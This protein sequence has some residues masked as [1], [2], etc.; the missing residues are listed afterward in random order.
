MPLGDWHGVST[1]AAGRVVALEVSR[2]GLVGTIPTEIAQ[3]SNLTRLWLDGN[4]LHGSIPDQLGNLSSL[5][6]LVLSGNRLTGAIPIQLG[7]L[8]GLEL[9]WLAGNRLTG[10]IPAALGN[11][12]ALQ[13]L[14]LSNNQF[15]GPV[16]R[17]LGNLANLRDLNLSRNRFDGSLPG[18]L[19][20]LANLT[21]LWLDNSLSRNL[22]TGPV[23]TAF[24]NLS[25][26]LEFSV[27]FTHLCAPSDE[28]FA[29]WYEAIPTVYGWL[30]PC[31]E[32]RPVSATSAGLEL[33]VEYDAD[34]D[35]TSVPSPADFEILV[36]GVS[37]SVTEVEVRGRVAVLTLASRLEAGQGVT[38]GYTPGDAPL[39]S[40][41]LI[42]APSL[43]AHP[44]P[45][46][47][48]PLTV[49]FGAASYAAEEGGVSAAVTIRLSSV[50]GRQ[51]VIPIFASLTGGT[52]AE[53]YSGVPATVTFASHETERTFGFAA[54]ADEV[55]DDGE[56]VVLGFG[57]PLPALV[58]AGTTRTTTV[59]ILDDPADVP[60]VSLSY[61]SAAYAVAEGGSV[62]VTV[63]LSAMPE[64]L[65]EIP[66]SI[67]HAGGSVAGDYSGVPASVTFAADET[68]RSFTFR[69]LPD[70]SEDD[71]ETVTLGFGSQL[72]PAVASADPSSATVTI[73]H[74]PL[75]QA[76]LRTLYEATDGPNWSNST[77]W[78]SEEPL[79]E[80]HGIS[81]STDHLVISLR[82][83]GLRGS[84]PPELG[85]LAN[86]KVLSLAYNQLSGPIPPEL[87]N[88]TGLRELWLSGNEALSGSIPS[89]A[90]NLASLRYLY[91]RETSLAG[92][93]P[94]RLTELTELRVLNFSETEL[95]APA[96]AA[97]QT[98]ASGVSS[99]RGPT[100]EVQVSTV[101]PQ[102]RIA[103]GPSP[104]AEG[105]A[106]AFTLTR[107]GP[108]GVALTVTVSVTEG[109]AMLAANPPAS[110]IFGADE[111]SAT[112]TAATEDDA[113]VEEASAVTAAI[114]SGE[115]YTA[116]ADAGSA[117][118]SVEDND[119]ATFEVSFDREAIAEGQAATLTV[120]IANG[121]TFAEDQTIALDFAGGTATK[122]TDYTVP[123]ESLVLAAGSTSA[124][125]TVTA[126]DDTDSEGAE[127][128][129]VAARHE[130]AAI[131]S[132]SVTIEASDAAPPEISI[133]AGTSPVTEGTAAAF[134]LTRTGP[135]TE[136]LAVAVSVT[137]SAA[138]LAA[139]PA[140]SVTF[141]A[142]ESS[143][144][145]TVATDDDAV[146]EGSSAVTAAVASG[147][148]YS[149][150][151]DAG[152]AQATVEDNDAPVWTVSPSAVEVAEGDTA[153]LT[154]SAG[155]VTFAE[156]Q[157]LEL[158]TAGTA[159]AVDFALSPPAPQIAAGAGSVAV[160]VTAVDDAAEEKAETVRLTVLHGGGGVGTATVTIAA[161]DAATGDARLADLTLS[162]GELA[163]RGEVERYAMTVP[164]DL[165]STTVTATPNDP[166]AAVDVSPADTDSDPANGHQVR[167]AEGANAVVVTV[168]S[169]DGQATKT[170][171]VQVTRLAADRAEALRRSERDLEDLSGNVPF[172]LWSE[173]GTLW[174]A[175]WWSVGLV[176]FDLETHGRLSGRDIAVA[177]D[178]PSPT[179]LWS[180]GETLWASDYGGGVFGYRLSDGGRVPGEDL[181]ATLK[182]A[183][184]DTPTGL[185]SDGETLWVADH[186]DERVYAYRL[187]DKARDED[188]EFA[189]EEGTR[190][191]GLWSDGTTAWTADLSAGRVAAYRLSD[192]VRDADRDY[193]TSTVGNEA[194]VSLWS[195]G[196]TLWVG[197]R[198]DEKLYAY[199]LEAE[200]AEASADATL[201]SLTLS[202]V[203]IGTFD[204]ATAD[205][206]ASV[207]PAVA[208]TT[209]TATPTSADASVTIA[210]S[211][212][213]TTDG[214]RDVS[215]A[216]GANTVTATVTA[217]DGQTT[218]T[219][220][221][222]VTREYAALPAIS[223]A[224]GTSPVTEG[225][226]AAFTLTRTGLTAEARTVAVSVTESGA[227]LAANPPASVTFGTGE[228]SATL[229]A[230]TDDDAVVEGASAVTAAVASGEG[231]ATAANA[232]SAQVSV[233]DNDAATFEVSFDAEAIAEGQ[234]ATLTVGIANGVT[235]A[236][237]QTIALD[238]AGGTATKGTDYTVSAESV[239]LAAGSTSVQATL[240]AVDDTDP[241]GAETV[242][243]A[244][245]HEGAAI[246]SASMTLEA[247][248]AALP[249][250]SIAAGASPVT[251]GKAAAFTLTRTGPTAEALTVAVS[252][253]E[254]TAMLVANPPSS[255][256]FGTG[257]S[258]AALTVATE[259]DAVVEGASTVTAV[260]AIGEGY[261]A[262]AN[263]A[264]AQVTVEDN[265]TAAF[266]VTAAPEAIAEGESATLTVAIANGVTFAEDQA[267]AL[268]LSGT[269]SA[270][271]YAGLPAALT[272][273]AGASSTAAE[274]T[275]SEDREDEEPETVMVAASHGGVA[276]GSATVTIRSVSHDA[277]LAALS[278]SGVDIG[279][280]A[281]SQ[282]SYMAS[283]AHGTSGTTVTATATHSGAT[284]AILPGAEVSLAEGANEIA[285]TVTA[286]DG[287]TA[288]TY[289]VTVTRVGLPAVSIAGASSPVTEGMAAA[290]EVTL[291][292]AA[293][294]PLTVALSVAESGSALSGTPPASVSF[295]QGDT[296]ATLSVPTQG[297]QV[298]EA[299]S[300]VTA[301]VTAGAG[302]TLGAA[303]SA[304]V[305]VEDDDEAAFTVTAA[306]EAIAEGESATLT[307]A[308]SNGATFAEDQS[309]ALSVSGTASPADYSGL[310]AAVTL[311]A[312]ASAVT[313]ELAAEADQAEEEAETVT[314][315]AAHAGVS[316]GSATV[317]I[318]SVSHDATLAALSLSGVDIGTFSS[319][320]TVYTASV[321]HDISS[322]TV[323]A[324]AT[325]PR[326][327]VSILPSTE[328][329][330][331]EGV[332]EI[333]VTVTAED[334]RSTQTYAVTVTRVGLPV[335]SIVA[336][337]SPVSEGERV[338]YTVSRT[339]PTTQELTVQASWSYSDR[340]EVQTMPVLFQAGRR[341]KIPH[342]QKHD[343]KVI[344]EDVTV[345]LTLED[346]EGYTVAAE[347]RSAQVVLEDNDVAQFAL[348]LD[349]GEIAE[350][351]SGT[352][353]VEITNGVTF[354][355]DQAITF[356]F[357]GSTATKG[358][359][360]AVSPES[361]TLRSGADAATATVTALDD[362][363]EE[364]GETV[365]VTAKHAGGT[366]GT[367]TLTITNTAF[368]PLTAQFAGVPESHDGMAAFGF[369]LRFSE[370]PAVSYRTLRDTAFEVAGGTV[371]RARRLEPPS[372]LRWQITAE[373]ASGAD[374]T[375]VLP[376]SAACDKPAAICTTGGKPLSS[377][378]EATIKGPGSE[379]SGEGFSLAPA[380]SSPSGLWSDGDTAWVADLEDARLYAYRSEDG[381]RLPDRDI[382]TGPAPM[383]LW[384][385][386][387]TL[388]V[389]GL[390][391]GL[392]AHR[393]SNG[394]RLVARDLALKASAAPSGVWSDGKTVWVSD[395]LGD[396][397]HAYRLADG[398]REAGRDIRLAGGNLMPVGLWSDGETLW[399][400]D[401]R[402]LLYA[403]RLSDGGREPSRDVVAG[404]ADSDPTGLWSG[405]GTL[406]STS[407]EGSRVRAYRLPALPVSEG[408]P[409]KGRGGFLPARAAS[410]PAIPDPALKTAIGAALG[411]ASGEAVSLEELAG[412]E[413]LEA[414]EAGIR[415]LAGLEA[416]ASLKELDLGFNPLA[417]LRPLAALPRLESLNLDGAVADLRELA[418][419]A[420]VKRLSLR[421][422]GIEDL[423]PLAGLAALAEL[424][425][426]DN[427]IGDL[428][429]LAGLAGLAVLRADR[430]LIA[431]LWPLAPLSGL[432]VL[433]LGANQLRD[434]Q[435]LAGLA[436]LRML[437]LAG[438][439][440]AE[441]HPLSRL[442]GLQDLG[443]GGNAVEDLHALSGLGGLRRLDLRGNPVRDLRPLR[444]LPSLVWVHVGGSRIED[445]APLDGLPGL[446]VAG[447]DDRDS[448]GTRSDRA[449]RAGKQ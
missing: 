137:E 109:G 72:P 446:T 390:G 320:T 40:L 131:G 65:L 113:V 101:L 378:L 183:G 220:T 181:A 90:A 414:R 102:V 150:A 145:L 153:T 368:V 95:C 174:S 312:G 301:T 382:G 447:P 407:W 7:S 147:E 330:L 37:R 401:W 144:T 83:N 196:E 44:L 356:E 225:T 380:N 431:D 416:A 165:E 111:S 348:S 158:R 353:R 31:I 262:A 9:L 70:Q 180:D 17:E 226:A 279:T 323:T 118:V 211:D 235:F 410:L 329:S 231:Y 88:L 245:R 445:L 138:M 21:Q 175:M 173:D 213:S 4:D 252:V 299:D 334:G 359:D 243:V 444:A 349:P 43:V 316:I 420:S 212:G 278:L 421:H 60:G 314:V 238:F 383:G 391:G 124:R 322:T 239:V 375:V 377:R 227:M 20:N 240:T 286:E 69:A 107:T 85:L 274:L 77:N 332:N 75:V 84:I 34:L 360:Y 13:D 229:T 76:V 123:A 298:V 160:S 246:G 437:R 264:S 275:A 57:N 99:F 259:D 237:D 26:L 51:T 277:T 114:A 80:W 448:P 163:F 16:P 190:A 139:N 342:V 55:D 221:V 228:S 328:V 219:Y 449:G 248:D 188:R 370:E 25:K 295:A 352:V 325:H 200:A 290:F 42:E 223:I 234:A 48:L 207:G 186:Y 132:A 260:V 412:L 400:A 92:P 247:S 1:D 198:Y 438:N 159:D 172:G 371:R 185:W 373:P 440:L 296:S 350:G 395:W 206:A 372:N 307:V 108:T 167:L 210:D 284:V 156:A 355:E 62:N 418:A 271:D 257:E 428:S 326:A 369:E 363:D 33:H 203:N 184:N 434:L 91:L 337:A 12:A 293:P 162:G 282:T 14:D 394:A 327:T 170:Y 82:G 304:T 49:E 443:L 358:A 24:A 182:A 289:T 218:A 151:A 154:V 408:A 140:A 404:A 241:E 194:P 199:A 176:A 244:A 302:Y 351:E 71:G 396:T 266:T 397:V 64:R 288:K 149:A 251:E 433:D 187:A 417:D 366:I 217:A 336:V 10:S 273:Q 15:T 105:A 201:A 367:A 129:A 357:A 79:S 106:A 177:S 41:S 306:P 58:I 305:T 333:A 233:E 256:R 168:V 74:A 388:W 97:F 384:S 392:H 441:L 216:V 308:I 423:G 272:L 389:A 269:A 253:T 143:A 310:P 171:T 427:R 6:H 411:K 169:E 5:T 381:E 430:N 22:L 125:A 263:G 344:R 96:D 386:G 432:E 100:C 291:G 435:P 46:A 409:G 89:E 18:E 28:D 155:A 104:V 419:L 134:T 23:P 439:G 136:A 126:V 402:E 321:A 30:E 148:G 68:E 399:V 209:V 50:P 255:A 178:N 141:G 192:G 318:R 195:D 425:V 270:A 343:D 63:R 285:V 315:A 413:A 338:A 362:T 117:Q 405:G 38:V 374:V 61:G 346:G 119:A 317:T 59:T 261:S 403:Y 208:S 94:N 98:W 406:L 300:A 429:P 393:L 56:A 215:L 341:S 224:A 335:V 86:L 142:D 249:E 280:F 73:E 166:D 222:T 197:D 204:A 135:A 292:A 339:G 8:S 345:T 152:S 426:G 121:V 415:D 120:A 110:V 436:R 130:G 29:A 309:V 232:G 81:G 276:I 442:E 313:A 303:S 205:Y 39:R 161:N 268:A 45:V 191:F 122:G 179:G 36:D 103:A 331:A 2:N 54:L 112:L 283:V 32:P 297:D 133:V 127:T 66:L 193:D 340:A 27:G 242:A 287:T 424:D 236:E 354:E 157:V 230:A 164:K 11:L 364:S 387:K 265:D 385:D 67:E 347:A 115:G 189:L 267:V 128:V 319:D 87:W 379:S 258:S 311:A 146:V 35:T 250:I 254:S 52:S 365:S 361:L 93:L 422:N 53:D 116:A 281:S 78:L 324:A 294:G 376:A 398:R 214:P 47:L 19:G 202:G 3:L